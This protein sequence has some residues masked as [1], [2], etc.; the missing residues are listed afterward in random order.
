VSNILAPVDYVAFNATPIAASD[1]GLHPAGSPAKNRLELLQVLRAI[2]VFSVVLYH[3]N[4]I[5]TKKYGPPSFLNGIFDSGYAG[6]DLFFVLSGFVIAL[7]HWDDIGKSERVGRYALRRVIRILPLYWI[8]VGSKLV[9]GPVLGITD[10]AAPTQS[11]VIRGLLLLPQARSF[12]TERMLGLSWTLTFEMLFYVGFGLCMAFG[13]RFVIGI[14]AIAFVLCQ[15]RLLGVFTL[16]DDAVLRSLF[17]HQVIFEFFFGV[18]IAWAYRNRFIWCPRLLVA[19]GIASS[20]TSIAGYQSGIFTDN[21]RMI[22]FGL[23]AALLVAG[24]VGME[25]TRPRVVP[26]F[27]IDFG[28]ASYATYL[29]HGSTIAI[30]AVVLRKLPLLDGP[31]TL[32]RNV[33][34]VACVAAAC[35]TGHLLHTR[36]EK[37]ILRFLR[38]LFA[39]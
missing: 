24:C 39:V 14:C 35:V 33:I 11:E 31:S 38:K 5:L 17:S 36:V 6:V 25:T 32:T 20:A 8:V 19:M 13:R 34:G 30:V 22:T 26:K 9:L 2:A 3:V 18:A 10:A 23:S 16:A 12:S 29:A 21:Q 15:A 1:E 28:D 27:L 7:T 4:S 37:P